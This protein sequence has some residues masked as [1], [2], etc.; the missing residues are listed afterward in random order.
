MT[1]SRGGSTP[2]PK[3]HPPGAAD[4]AAAVDERYEAIWN[5]DF[6]ASAVDLRGLDPATRKER[7]RE[8]F[9]SLDAGEECLIVSDR[10]PAPVRG[11]LLDHVDADALP[12][13]RVK[14]QN[15]ETWFARTTHP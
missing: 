1:P 3:T 14:R 2:S 11:F 8:R 10:D 6:P 4:L 12:S 9:A 13:F 15:P 7:V 5:V